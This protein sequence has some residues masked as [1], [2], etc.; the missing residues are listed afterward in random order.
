M[1]ARFSRFGSFHGFR[2]VA[3]SVGRWGCQFPLSSFSPIVLQDHNRGG[4]FETAAAPAAAP[5][6][7]DDHM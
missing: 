5:A 6:A 7:A 3:P 4:L 2:Q 1:P